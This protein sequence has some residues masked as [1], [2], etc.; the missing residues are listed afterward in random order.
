MP[1]DFFSALERGLLEAYLAPEVL[2]YDS[3]I[4]SLSWLN[5]LAV[6]VLALTLSYDTFFKVK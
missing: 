1:N 6:W 5:R 2:R 3:R 4:R